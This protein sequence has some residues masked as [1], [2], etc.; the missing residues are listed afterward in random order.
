MKTSRE[1]IDLIKRFEGCRLNAYKCPAGVWTIGYGHTGKD[2]CEGM[3]INQEQAEALLV[4]DILAVEQQLERSVKVP[5]GIN[6]FSAL[7]SFVFNL[8]IA[9]FEVSTLAR[10]IES[11]NFS[12]AASQFERWVYSN[13]D[14]LSGLVERRKAERELFETKDNQC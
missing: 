4:K 1:A 9:K 13:N 5:L 12:A 3:R 8:G 11:G 10:L 2:V 14:K 7:V 6:Q